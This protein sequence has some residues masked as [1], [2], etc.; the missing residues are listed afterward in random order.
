MMLVPPSGEP[1]GE[2][3]KTKM[4]IRELLFSLLTFRKNLELTG[5]QSRFQVV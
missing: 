3:Q 1:T 4:Q 2:Q 5:R